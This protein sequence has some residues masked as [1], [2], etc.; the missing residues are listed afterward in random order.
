MMKNFHTDRILLFLVIMLFTL[1]SVIMY[2]ASTNQ[3]QDP[4]F[5]LKRHLFNSAVALLV[6]IFFARFP[7]HLYRKLL[8]IFVPIGPAL[9]VAVLVL[10]AHNGSHQASRWLHLGK[11]SFQASDAARLTVIIALAEFLQRRQ[12]QLDDLKKTVLPLFAYI[13]LMAGLVAYEPDLSTAFMLVLISC[14]MCYLGNIR[15]THLS[16]FFST[17]TV[18]GIGFLITHD[19]M[20]RR[21]LAFLNPDPSKVQEAFQLHQS[22][23]SLANGSLL[24]VGLGNSLGKDWFVPEPHTDFVFSILGEE[25]GFIGAFLVLTL[26]LLLFL[27]GVHIARNSSDFFSMLLALGIS[28]SL[29]LYVLA[30]VAVVIGILPTTGLPLPLISYGGSNLVTTAAMLGILFNISSGNLGRK[31]VFSPLNRG[32]EYA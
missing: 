31:P 29:F 16:A 3:A 12:E 8:P 30:N 15:L 10:N 25:F 6:G 21:V 11:F 27:R 18:A 14:I 24:G 4:T 20:W 7:H 9:L 28:S 2:S 5:Y 22:L 17:I 32:F 23:L 19:Y 1:G 26:F 13:G